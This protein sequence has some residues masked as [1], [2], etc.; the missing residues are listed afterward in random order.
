[1]THSCTTKTLRRNDATPTRRVTRCGDARRDRRN[2]MERTG[3]R[4][5]EDSCRRKSVRTQAT[6]VTALLVIFLLLHILAGAVLQRAGAPD[7]SP[8][9]QDLPLKRYD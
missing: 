4:P 6:L 8:S 1:M 7:R 5:T 3:M 9:T 2:L